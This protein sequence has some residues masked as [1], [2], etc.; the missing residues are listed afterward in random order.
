MRMTRYFVVSIV[1]WPLRLRPSG[2]KVFRSDNSK[3]S[4]KISEPRR[5]DM[6]A[7]TGKD[8]FQSCSTNQ[9]DQGDLEA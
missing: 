9:P 7:K 4:K 3:T 8:V 2:E 5:D 6:D 1:E